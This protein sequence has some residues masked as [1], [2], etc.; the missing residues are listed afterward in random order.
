MKPT[1]DAK[2][3]ALKSYSMWANY[4]GIAALIAPELIYYFWYIDTNPKLWWVLGLGLILFGIVGRLIDQGI[5]RSPFIVAVASV[6][7]AMSQVPSQGPQQGTQEAASSNYT[8]SEFLSVAI[9]HIAK[10]EGLRT[11]AYKDIVGVW[12][13]CYGETKGVQPGDTYTKAQC[14]DMLAREVLSYR[15]GWHDYLTQETLSQRLNPYRDTAYT[16]LAYNVGIAGAGNSTAT[17]RLNNGNIAG[18]CEAI[19]WWNKAGNRVVRGLVNRRKDDYE[20]CMKG[21]A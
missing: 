5:T 9:P 15:E 16:S 6:S 17:R 3:I 2:K 18:G 10:W 1:K 14:E 13:V 21:L 7:L 4:L 20:L 11:E 19:T 12:T 8:Q